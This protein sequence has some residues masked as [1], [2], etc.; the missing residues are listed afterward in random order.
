MNSERIDRYRTWTR[1]ALVLSLMLGLGACTLTPKKAEPETVTEMPA[2]FSQAAIDS[3]RAKP[4]WW[5]GYNDEV[6]NQ[7]VDSTLQ[8]N[9]DLQAAIARVTEVQNLYRIQ[10][11]DLFPSVQ[12]G[13]DLSNQNTPANTGPTGSIGEGIPSFPSRFETTTY[14]ASLG[15]N[16]EID[17]WGRI[18][19]A[20]NA[21]LQEYFA[22][23][24]DLQAVVLGVLSETIA[25]YFEIID[26]ERQID[27]TIA[28]LDLLEERVE[29]SEDRYARG[30]LT[31]FELYSVR[32]NLENVR[33][34]L[35]LVE[36]ALFEA[37][38]RM[39]ILT[40]AYPE[41]VEA[42]L[43][44]FRTASLNMDPIPAGLPSQLLQERPDVVA[45]A[46]RLEGARQRIGAAK[47]EQFPRIALTASGGVQSGDLSSLL[48]YDQRFMSFVASLTAPIFNGGRLKANVRVTEAQYEQIASAYEKAVLVA[49]KEVES[50][51]V[52]YQKEQE[53]YAFLLGE[54]ESAESS[55]ET[56]QRRFV[57]GVGDY[58][59][60]LDARINLARVQSNVAGA[61]RALATS[62]L[63][64]HRALGGG[65]VTQ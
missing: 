17:L 39:G 65:W 51:L 11:A 9:L 62:R 5:T 25:T 20:K 10:R 53:R 64:V 35:P 54:L 24:A 26:L 63:T 32:Q 30:L 40:G 23:Q 46:Q 43:G 28:N 7:L 44:D 18:R 2:S 58:L 42:L 60:Y 13:A 56:Q 22:S 48:N 61:E 29:L 1:G 38:G 27:I 33:S 4:Y 47:A 19:S 31:S 12:L 8:R 49:F 16:Y 52:A 41:A 21:A 6:L 3:I 14:S 37:K 34:T 45:A 36:S 55:A 50:S 57:R 59:A 15:L